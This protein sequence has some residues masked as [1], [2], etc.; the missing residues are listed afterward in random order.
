M[1]ARKQVMFKHALGQ[2]GEHKL[3]C[4]FAVQSLLVHTDM[5]GRQVEALKNINVLLVHNDL[6]GREVD[7][8]KQITY[9]FE[10][11][12]LF[13]TRPCSGC[14]KTRDQATRSYITHA[15]ASL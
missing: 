5:G 12:I 3:I 14:D 6:G 13:A 9:N 7:A 4:C 10:T 8:R 11:Y 15:H 1:R 2:H